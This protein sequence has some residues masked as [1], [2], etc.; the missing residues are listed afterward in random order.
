MRYLPI[1]T[2]NEE[3]AQNRQVTS[4]F[5]HG[6]KS[7]RKNPTGRRYQQHV[8]RQHM[9]KTG[10]V[11]PAAAWGTHCTVSIQAWH[12]TDSVAQLS[13]AAHAK[14]NL[15]N[16]QQLGSLFYPLQIS[17]S[18]NLQEGNSVGRTVS[19]SLPVPCSITGTTKKGFFSF[20]LIVMP[21]GKD[22]IAQVP[23]IL[24]C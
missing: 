23:Q 13:S 6:S 12:T 8:H 11:S 14:D 19:K 16:S 17:I 3:Q 24:G 2:I 7:T 5:M 1:S 20:A 22:L 18:L 4:C 9:G 15:V 21:L 10:S